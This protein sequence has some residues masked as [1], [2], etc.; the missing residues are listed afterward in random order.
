MMTIANALDDPM[1]S[2]KLRLRAQLSASLLMF[3]RIFFKIRTG[4]EFVLSQPLGRESHYITIARALQNVIDGKCKRLIINV[5]PRYAKTEM[6]IHFVAW[7]IAQY[8]DSN[9]N[10]I[11]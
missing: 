1:T 8:P 5:P 10:P 4:R 7:A 6:L 9:F 11:L 2:E 3:V